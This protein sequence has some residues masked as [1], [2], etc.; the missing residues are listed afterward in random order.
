MNIF[1][2]IIIVTSLI[3]LSSTIN[4]APETLHGMGIQKQWVDNE[5]VNDEMPDFVWGDSDA[6][7]ANSIGLYVEFSD[8][9]EGSIA[10]T[11]ISTKWNTHDEGGEFGTLISATGFFAEYN[12]LHYLYNSKSLSNLPIAWGDNPSTPFGSNVEL[13]YSEQNGSQFRIDAN[14]WDFV[15]VTTYSST[16]PLPTQTQQV[17]SVNNTPKGVLGR[18]SVLEVAYDTTDNNN[19]LSGLGMRVHFD[20]SLLSFKEIT[21]LIEQDIIVDGQ[22]PFSDD[23]DFDN[24]PLTDQ[25]MLFGWA[26]L[27]NNWPNTELP[28]VLMNIAFDVSENINTDVISSTNIN[29]TNTSFTAGY[30]FSAESY[31]LEILNATW[32]FDGNGQADALTDGLMMLRYLFGLSDDLVTNG[33]M[34]INSP[35]D[36]QQVVAEIEAAM[37]IADIDADGELNALTDGLLLLRY[38]FDLRDVLLTNGVVGPEATRS[39]NADIQGYLDSHMPNQPSLLDLSLTVSVE[40][41]SSVRLTGPWWGWDQN[42]GPQ[43]I[44][45]GDGTWTV[46]LDPAPTEYMQYL[47]V[48]DGVFEVLHDNAANAQCGAEIDGGTLV[49][50]YANWSARVWLLGLGHVS[51]TYGACLGSSHGQVNVTFQVNMDGVDTTNGVSVMGGAV[52]GQAGV[53]MYDDDGDK[54]WTVTT[55]LDVNS[56]VAFKYRNTT[57]LTWDG[58]EP[59]SGDCTFGEWNDRQVDVADSD[60]TLDVVAFGNC[61]NPIPA[62]VF[63]FEDNT[64]EYPSYG[65]VSASFA[66]QDDGGVSRNMLK[67]VNGMGAEWWSGVTIAAEYVDTDFLG[68]GTAP[69]TMRVYAEQDGNL[70]LELEANGHGP[71]VVNTAVTQGWNDL[72]FDFSG[73]DAAVNWHKIQIRPDALG[74]SPNAAETVYYIDDI[75]FPGA[76]IVAAPVVTVPASPVPTDAADSVLSIFS[77]AYTD[78][79]GTDFN[80]GWGQATQVTV[81]DGVVTYAGLNYQG[82]QFANSDV[83]GYGYIHLDFYTTDATDLQFTIISPGKENLISLTDQIVSGQW[84]SVEIPLTDFIADLTDV[85]QFKVVGNGTVVLDNLY[86]GGTA[87]TPVAQVNVTFQVNMDGVDTTNGVSVMGGYIFGQTGI[88]MSDDDGDNIWTVTTQLVKNTNVMF[89]Y[90]NT[91]ALT[92]D[93]IEFIEGDCVFGEWNDRQVAVAETDITLPVVSFGG[94]TAQPIAMD[95]I[96]LVFDFEDNTVQYPSYGGLVASFATQDDAGDTRNMLK[97]VNGANSAW[98]SGVTIAALPAG[99]DF[100]GNGMTPITMRVYAEQNGDIRLDLEADGRETSFLNQVVTQGWNNLSFDFSGADAAINWHKIQIRPDALGEA[101]N[102]AET[103][104]YIDD[105]TFPN[106]SILDSDDDGVNDLV[107]DLPY[108]ATE[109]VDSDGD[110]VGDNADVFPNDP[111]RTHYMIDAIPDA[112]MPTD[113]ADY[114]LSIFSNAYTNLEGT[115]FNPNWGQSTSVEVGHNLIYSNLNYQGTQFA[116]QDVSDY[117]YLNV[118]YYVDYSLFESSE[119]NFYLISPGAEKSFALD[120]SSAEQWNRVQIPLSHYDNVNLADVFQFKVDGNGSVAFNNIYFGGG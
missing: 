20:S 105:V 29:F 34:A 52:F 67:L 7:A 43:A 48:V 98:W 81:A 8:G 47:W 115:D 33:A 22:G 92:W 102:A 104:Y 2:N 73:T 88:A 54:I 100:L 84:V 14:N 58:Q 23:T 15:K 99:N 25:Y 108:D 41:A 107:D 51:D 70:N 74:Q 57:A 111:N 35:F 16:A 96:D 117:E 112:P 114:V 89:K 64:V 68:D 116:N 18:T 45:N 1:K 77:D 103:T 79:A 119:I 39:S 69:A 109:A 95:M 21:G 71:A 12:S 11:D 60:I 30:E 19:Q 56:T 83:S 53:A 101:N 3:I 94:C 28:T 37:D 42:G 80:P 26:S 32:D 72:S 50:D 90:R 85:F 118:D 65:G 9:T 61:D 86:F 27:Y 38:L 17:I 31:E 75:T 59:V 76:T 49:T 66:T 13:D 55:P 24:D 36:S 46:T 120:L 82:T 62:I 106:A 87:P 44:D 40:E 97:L 93:N 63:D 5:G 91:T 110:G 113:A 6:K 78:L 4:A 10:Y